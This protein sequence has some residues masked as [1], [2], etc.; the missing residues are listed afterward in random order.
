[1]LVVHT[2]IGLSSIEGIGLFTRLP[3]RAGAVVWKNDPRSHLKIPRDVAATMPEL[4][5]A[6]LR[7]HATLRDDGWFVTW[8]N[9]QFIN[10]SDDANLIFNFTGDLIAA[11]DIAANEE[12]TEN[13]TALGEIEPFPEG[14]PNLWHAAKRPSA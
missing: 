9:S 1:M 8:D 6:F 7:S 5:Q 13:Y 2:D 11:R 3:I 10:H 12:L 14:D 4:T